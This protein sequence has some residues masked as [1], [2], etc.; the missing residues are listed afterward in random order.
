MSAA[1]FL[2]RHANS[3][4]LGLWASRDRTMGSMHRNLLIN[5][6]QS[7]TPLKNENN[8]KD[9]ILKFVREFKNC[10]ERRKWALRVRQD[11]IRTEKCSGYFS[12]SDGQR[13]QGTPE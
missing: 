3:N 10:F 9:E 8:S 2:R 6:I 11:A 12:A 5:K 7:Y 4:A 13:T 1:L